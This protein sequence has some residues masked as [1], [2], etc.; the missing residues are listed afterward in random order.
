MQYEI[1]PVTHYQQNCSLVW[2]EVTMQAAVIDP[3]GEIERILR[4]IDAA[5]VTLTK[6]ILTHGHMDHVGGAAD[7]AKATGVPIIGP[8]KEDQFWL[9]ILDQQA[10][11]MGFSAQPALVP[12]QWLN[13]GD[14]VSVGEQVLAVYHCPG[15]TPGH[16]VLFNA[17]AKLAWV[18]DVLFKGS[19]GRT[20]FPRGDYQTLVDSILSKL[21]PLGDDVT[22]IP[23]HGGCS[24]FGDERRSNPFVA[25]KR[26]G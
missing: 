23:G 5:G 10:A 11:M 1:I 9:S 12:T 21:W 17:A 22:F 24:S 19:I 20:D 6:I 25:D 26:F 15:H 3:G 8:H 4:R 13:D 18:G 16:V 2:C 14:T 7:L